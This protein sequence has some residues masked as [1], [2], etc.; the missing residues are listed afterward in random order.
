MRIFDPNCVFYTFHA[1]YHRLRRTKFFRLP[2]IFQVRETRDFGGGKPTSKC[3]KIKTRTK[4]KNL[5]REVLDIALCI[6]KPHSVSESEANRE[7]R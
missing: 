4:L 7:T 3:Y 6:P 1:F 5:A 2:K